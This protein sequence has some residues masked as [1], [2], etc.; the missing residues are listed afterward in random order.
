MQ[1]EFSVSVATFNNTNINQRFPNLLAWLKLAKLIVFCLK[2]L[3]AAPKC[4]APF[5]MVLP[6][7]WF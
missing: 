1:Q 6:E 4:P 3:E 7:V 5:E 2:A